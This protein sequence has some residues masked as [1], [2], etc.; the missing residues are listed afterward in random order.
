MEA[1]PASTEKRAKL[2]EKYIF[3]GRDTIDENLTSEELGAGKEN[4]E[5]LLSRILYFGWWNTAVQYCDDLVVNGFDDWYLPSSKELAYMYGNLARK[6]LG[7]FRET[8][9]WSSSGNDGRGGG[10]IS[11]GGLK[12]NMKDGST[13]K[14]AGDSV[15]EQLYVRAARRF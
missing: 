5:Y 8:F 4:A 10:Q 9:Y 3:H 2:I 15:N 14:N 13:G 12:V 1:A 11:Y 6:E 7:G